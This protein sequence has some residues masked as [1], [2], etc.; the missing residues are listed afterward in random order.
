[1]SWTKAGARGAPS[2]LDSAAGCERDREKSKRSARRKKRRSKHK[3]L[4]KQ[5]QR[6]SSK[7]TGTNDKMEQNFNGGRDKA[8]RRG[9][10]VTGDDIMHIVSKW[11]GDDAETAMEQKETQR[12]HQK[13]RRKLKQQV[14]WPR[15]AVI[16]ISRAVATL[17]ADLKAPRRPIGSFQL[18]S[19][20]ASEKKTFLAVPWR[21]SVWF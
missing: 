12:L 19:P 3:I 16:R 10:V 15:R 6:A 2:T 5:Q 20:P 18:S 9:V 14:H 4:K 1:M 7:K 11:D 13:W 21:N 17:R 8:R